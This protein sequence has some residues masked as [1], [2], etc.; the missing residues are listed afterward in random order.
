MVNIFNYS[1][2]SGKIIKNIVLL[3]FIGL[4]W[5]QTFQS[6][7]YLKVNEVSFCMS[8]CSSFYLESEFGDFITFISNDNET[9]IYNNFINR[10]V[11]VVGNTIVCT[12][13]V[14]INAQTITLSSQCG[15]PVSCFTDPCLN[16]NCISSMNTECRSNYCGGCYADYYTTEN[17]EY[18]NCEPPTGVID[19]TNIDFGDCDM[20]LGVGWVN[21]Q[22]QL[23]SGCGWN[24]NDIDYSD[25]FFDSMEECIETSLL[26]INIIKPSNFLINQNYPNPFNP[27]TS[28][29]YN[30]PVDEFV[31]ITIY[32]LLGNIVNNLLND[33]QN[34]G[35]KSIQW[36]ATSNKGQTVPAGIYFYSIEAG[37]FKKT[38]K[39]L[40]VK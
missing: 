11:D 31:K 15:N 27:I 20:A 26:H 40:L 39:M 17:D 21:N 38:K 4:A 1:K 34:S 8:E 28:I 30:L 22:C 7:G 18:I 36:N 5:G 33:K 35:Y 13:C 19:L 24:V 23:V 12:E 10:F 14:S 25:A 3:F 2:T 29:R 32:D 9:I 16:S 37:K 6:Q